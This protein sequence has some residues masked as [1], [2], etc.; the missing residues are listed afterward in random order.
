[1]GLFALLVTK[2]RF[3]ILFRGILELITMITLLV[4]LVVKC[5][6]RNKNLKK[7]L[8]FVHVLH[9]RVRC[10]VLVKDFYSRI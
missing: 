10:N 7:K 1:M 9:V 4:D 6:F 8:I 3:V 2:I 5:I